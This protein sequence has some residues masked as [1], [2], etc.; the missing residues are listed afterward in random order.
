MTEELKESM[1]NKSDFMKKIFKCV[2]YFNELEEVEENM[3]RDSIL[4]TVESHLETIGLCRIFDVSFTSIS[5]KRY[6]YLKGKHYKLN[7]LDFEKHFL[8]SEDILSLKEKRES[9]RSQLVEIDK[10]IKLKEEN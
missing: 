10:L 5:D 8:E 3:D 2:L 4:D 6:S 7:Q 1:Q 9:L